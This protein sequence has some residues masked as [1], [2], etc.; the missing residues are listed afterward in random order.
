MTPRINNLAVIDKN[1]RIVNNLSRKHID[2]LEVFQT[3]FTSAAAEC[4][5]DAML[6]QLKRQIFNFFVHLRVPL[7]QFQT[8]TDKRKGYIEIL[9]SLGKSSKL[10]ISAYCLQGQQD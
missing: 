5:I 10:M 7:K 6:N 2:P 8:L 1:L 3:E 9:Q 4:A